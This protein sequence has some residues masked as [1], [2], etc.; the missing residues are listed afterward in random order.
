MMKYLLKG[1]RLAIMLIIAFANNLCAQTPADKVDMLVHAQM[2]ERHIPG[3]QVAIVQHGKIIY[4]KSFGIANIQ[5]EVPVTNTTLFPVHSITKAFAGV[6]IMQLV[7][8]GK[9]SL[10]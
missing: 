10:S 8:A 4:S 7:E 5:D 3:M 6:A 1:A 9:V 2:K